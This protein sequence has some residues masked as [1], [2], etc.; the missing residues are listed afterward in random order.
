MRLKMGSKAKL[1]STL[2]VASALSACASSKL[3]DNDDFRH[4]AEVDIEE[5]SPDYARQRK[6]AVNFFSEAPVTVLKTDGSNAFQLTMDAG[7][8]VPEVPIGRINAAPMEFGMLLNQ[9]AEQAGM[10]WRITGEGK[11]TLL[12][13]EVY[14]VQRNET[15]LKSVLDELS[16]L[17]GSFYRVEGDRIIFSQQARFVARVPRMANSQEILLEGL[18]NIGAENTFSDKLS[19]TV[20]FTA[21][22]HA[23][24]AARRLMASLEAGRDMIV[25]DF[26]IIERQFNNSSAAG[27][28]LALAEDAF[29]GSFGSTGT[30]GADGAVFSGSFGNVSVAAGVEFLTSLG[31]TKTVARPTITM[32]SGGEFELLDD[33]ERKLCRLGRR[34]RDQCRRG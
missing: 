11:D 34:E 4:L 5:R 26:W 2:L 3:P 19:G 18:G 14:F 20:T 30:E 10:S 32:L 7:Q 1:L 9:V 25:Y 22:R 16:E 12:S 15:M 13:E 23:Y 8:T 21:D 24:D 6:D 29:T 33:P 28:S 31:A 27:V 17:T